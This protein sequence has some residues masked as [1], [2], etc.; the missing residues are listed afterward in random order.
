MSAWSVPMATIVL[1]QVLPRHALLVTTVKMTIRFLVLQELTP[2]LINRPMTLIA[3]RATQH[4]HA[5][6]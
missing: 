6:Q 4:L 3:L 5:V 2:S 1:E